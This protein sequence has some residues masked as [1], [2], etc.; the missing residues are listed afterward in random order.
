MAEIMMSPPA[1]LDQGDFDEHGAALCG[2]DDDGTEMAPNGIDRLLRPVVELIP[3]S[4]R[5]R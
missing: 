5:Q 3:E 4:R 2:F 1:S